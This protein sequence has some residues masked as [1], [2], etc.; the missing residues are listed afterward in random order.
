M[1]DTCTFPPSPGYQSR[2]V[3]DQLT[4]NTHIN[5]TAPPPNWWRRLWWW[6]LLGIT[7]VDLRTHKE[8][9]K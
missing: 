3:L 4:P 7:W 6:A 9:D 5:L 2:L 8:K 1:E